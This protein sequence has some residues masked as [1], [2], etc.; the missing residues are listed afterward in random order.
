MYMLVN[1]LHINFGKCCNRSISNITETNLED[2]LMKIGETTIK[3]VS[4]TKF[5]CMIIDDNRL[6]IL[7][8]S[9]LEKAIYDLAPLAF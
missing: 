3:Q 1:K 7:K 8:F 6:G 2:C 4:D 9:I 5:L